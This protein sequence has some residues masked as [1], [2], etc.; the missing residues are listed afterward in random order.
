MK[1]GE[2]FEDY[3]KRIGVAPAIRQP[4]IVWGCPSCKKFG[5]LSNHFKGAPI[6]KKRNWPD[7]CNY[8]RCS[9]CGQHLFVEITEFP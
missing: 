8:F 2:S 4:S 5:I 6:K 3:Y 1:K 7:G 9:N